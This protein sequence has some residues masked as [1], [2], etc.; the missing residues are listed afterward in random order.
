MLVW[1]GD[2]NAGV[3]GGCQYWC[4]REM[5]MLVWHRDVNTGVRGRCQC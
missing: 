1:Q 3:A 4:G 2:V 5:S